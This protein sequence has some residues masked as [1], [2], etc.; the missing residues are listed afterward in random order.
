MLRLAELRFPEVE[1]LA[2]AG[3]ALV[4]VPVGSVEEHGVH[5]PLGLDTVGAEVYA[6]TAAPHLEREGYTVVL[7]PAIPYGVARPGLSFP[8]T[9]TLEPATLRALVVD[10]GR[11]LARHGLTRQVIFNGHRDLAH[12]GALE[13]GA[14][15][16]VAEG[17]AQ[18]VCVGFVTDRAT[19]RAFLQEGMEGYSRSARPDREAHGGEWAPSLAL[20]RI[21]EQV[22]QEAARR[23]EPNLDYDVE[24]FH[25]ETQDYWTLTG[26]RGYF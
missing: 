16:L 18:V 21:P 4:I 13:D 10:I 20:Y 24:G 7:A 9:L 26:G 19:L 1:A 3:R 23:L 11:S 22:D 14:R 25:S 8:G 12:M 6:E 17:T 5:L 2:R 15:T